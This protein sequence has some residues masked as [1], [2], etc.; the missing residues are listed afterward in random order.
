[1]NTYYEGK[2]PFIAISC[3][4]QLTVSFFIKI[5]NLIKNLRYIKPKLPISTPNYKNLFCQTSKNL[6]GSSSRR[7]AVFVQRNTK[8]TAFL[9]TA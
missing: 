3:N 6:L 9:G 1:M 2:I 4:Q 5:K 7:F 8:K